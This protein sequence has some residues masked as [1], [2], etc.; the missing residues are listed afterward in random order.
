MAA[1]GVNS[2]RTYTVPPRWLLD[3]AHRARPVGDD[4][5]PLGGAHH[6]PR[7][8]VRRRGSIE[9]QAPRR[10]SAP[11][12][13]I[14]AVLCYAIGN[15]I[16]ASIVRWHGRR[17]IERFLRRLYDAAKEEDPDALVTYVNYPSTEY[18]QLPFID[19][20]CFNVFLESGSP[21]RVLSRAS[22]EHRRRQAAARHRGRARLAA[23]LR[24][25][26]GA[27]RWTGRCAPRSPAAAPGMF[28]FSW[29]D[30]WHRGGYDVDDWAFGL[31]DRDRAPKQALATV[32]KAFSETPFRTD[33]DMAA[34]VGR[35]VRLQLREHAAQL[36]RRPEGAR[37][38]R[39]RGD[40]RQRRLHGPHRRD[41]PGVRL[42]T[43][44]HREPG[45]RERAQRG[46]ACG[47]RRDRRVHGRRRASRSALAV[48]PRHQLPEELARRHRRSQHPAARGRRGRRVRRERPRRPDPRAALRRDRRAHPRLQ[49]G[50]L[51][52][53]PAGDRRVR[54]AVLHRRRRRGHLLAPAAAGLD[55]RLQPRRSR[56]APPPRQRERVPQAA[57]RVRQGRGP[58]RAQVARALQPRR[59]PGLGRAGSTAPR[60]PRSCAAAGRST[61]APGVRA[62]SSPFTTARP[63]S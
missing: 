51:E 29:T 50:L 10:P 36:L 25:G 5:H 15:E 58:A 21:V 38:S 49:H 60:P 52:V 28:V 42:P 37:L 8:P 32:G 24:G 53:Q 57:V 33:P 34:R 30:E 48:P 27:A 16:P 39:L 20:V 18:L 63:A 54:P 4:R 56:V 9:Q 22:S 46:P 17:R 2:V 19:L 41:H 13:A 44:Q 14:P 23:Q 59:A 31:V 43:D 7:R 3:L 62:C 26:A 47:D 35:R 11:A 55:R 45:P 12:R 6:V 61:T 1:N 40:R